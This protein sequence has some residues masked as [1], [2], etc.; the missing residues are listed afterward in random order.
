M[1]PL[2]IVSAPPD[3]Y[4]G[5][6]ARSR[7]FIKALKEVKGEEWDIKILSQRWGTTPWGFIDQNAEEWGW[8]KEMLIQQV[9]QQP[10]YW[11]QITVPNEFQAVG[12]TFSC[13]VTA[14]IETTICDPSWIEGVNRMNLTLV[15]SQHAKKVFTESSFDVQDQTGR[16]VKQIKLEKPVEV[17]FEGLDLNKYYYKETLEKTE[18]VD[19]LDSIKEDFCY[20]FV[21]HWI[22]GEIGHDR[23]NI[24]YMIRMFLEAFKNK[25]QRPALVLKTSL[26]GASIM[27]RDEILRRIDMIRK[28]IKGDLPSIYLLHGEMSDQDMNDLY[29]HKKV[30]AMVSFT[31]GEG[32]GRPLLEFT[33]SKKLV[34]ASGWSGHVDFLSPE[35][36]YLLSGK[37]HQLHPS[38]IV[39]NMLIKESSWFQPDDNQVMQMWKDVYEN[40]SKFEVPGKRQAHKAKTEF[41]YEAMVR[42]LDEI[43]DNK[44]TKAV[45]LK[46]P[47]LKKIELPKL[48]TI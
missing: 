35:F 8:M 41:S 10:D 12:K 32:Y 16:V 14:G 15:S 5:Y 27:D 34:I 17:L 22:Q 36:S 23:K 24:G 39:E 40:Y 26:A 18:L 20:L 37:L 47:Q 43:I 38:S 6:G 3:T 9:Q 11:F 48:Q 21:G 4:S 45:P 19:T 29:N 46:L 1:K 44:F 31:K 33:Q 13:G 30:K 7:D 42:L 2:C 28:S 25:K